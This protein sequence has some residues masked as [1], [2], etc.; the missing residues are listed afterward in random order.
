MTL[1]VRDRA[2]GR[3]AVAQH[4]AQEISD[5]LNAALAHFVETDEDPK[6]KARREF[7]EQAE[8]G[9]HMIASAVGDALVAMADM[10]RELLVECEGFSAEDE[11]QEEDDE[12]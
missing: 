5:S 11:D 3:I 10:G 8:F 12:D 6:G 7:L 9:A 1:T 4:C 2:L